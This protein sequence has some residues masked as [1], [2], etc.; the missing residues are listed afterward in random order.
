MYLIANEVFSIELIDGDRLRPLKV[1]LPRVDTYTTLDVHMQ[2]REKQRERERE[3]EREITRTSH[4]MASKTM[5]DLRVTSTHAPLYTHKHSN[6]CTFFHALLLCVCIHMLKSTQ[7]DKAHLR[8]SVLPLAG[9]VFTCT[10]S[11]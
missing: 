5:P 6:T 11:C 2:E 8:A 4:M 10:L 1:L 7:N 3:R 9:R